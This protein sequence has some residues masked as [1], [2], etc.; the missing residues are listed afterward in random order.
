MK[1]AFVFPGQGSQAV[2]MGKGLAEKHLEQ[3]NEVL[4]FDLKKLCFEGPEEALKKT[5]V[6]QPAILTVSVAAFEILKNKGVPMPAAVAGHSLGEYSA[7]VAA[8]ALSFSDAVKIVHLRGKFMQEAVPLGEGSMA[9]IIG[10]SKEEVEACCKR[11]AARGI[12]SAANLNSP[13]Q[14]VISGKKQAVEEAGRLCQE[15]GAKM[16]VPLQVSAPFHCILMQPAA[17]KLKVELGKIEI[18]NAQIPV[19]ANVTA[20]YV[21][22]GEEIRSLLLKQVTSPVLWEDSIKKMIH[23]GI[24]SFVEVGPGKVLSGLIKRIDRNTEVKSYLAL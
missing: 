16:T 23:D 4:G 9:A 20:D 17:E 15:A 21:S 24:K 22:N 5:E 18:K 8:S 2:G 3:A 12:V 10:L 11:A 14:I 19:V 1:S 6:T 7:L 13:G